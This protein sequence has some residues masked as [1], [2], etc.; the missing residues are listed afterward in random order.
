MGCSRL[1]KV[2]Q[3]SGFGPCADLLYLSCRQE[4]LQ[5]LPCSSPVIYGQHRESSI[6][7][8]LCS[9]GSI[10]LPVFAVRSVVL[11][12]LLE[13]VCSGACGTGNVSAWSALT[14]GWC[15]QMNLEALGV[16]EQLSLRSEWAVAAG[17][18]GSGFHT[19]EFLLGTLHICHSS[20]PSAHI[21]GLLAEDTAHSRK[22]NKN[23]AQLLGCARTEYTE[24]QCVF[25][26]SVSGGTVSTGLLGAGES[27]H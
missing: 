21:P 15:A 27:G 4:N 5:V 13:L 9:L 1:P 17:S 16:N 19:A 10:E 6:S 2:S 14:H 12:E 3:G 18:S 23:L 25:V 24:E 26:L 22:A 11:A 7:G 20:A 8:Y